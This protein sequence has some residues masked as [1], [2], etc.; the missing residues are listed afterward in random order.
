MIKVPS[1]LGV[2]EKWFLSYLDIGISICSSITLFPSLEV[3]TSD[4]TCKNLPIWNSIL[5]INTSVRFCIAVNTD[6]PVYIVRIVRSWTPHLVNPVGSTSGTI[7]VKWPT[8]CTRNGNFIFLVL[9]T[10]ICPYHSKWCNN[11]LFSLNFLKYSS[12]VTSILAV[13]VAFSVVS[14]AIVSPFGLSNL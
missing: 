12:F 1:P 4:F 10:W 5:D 14:D 11:R 13:F 7:R 8:P 2:T 6:T 9:S 3:I